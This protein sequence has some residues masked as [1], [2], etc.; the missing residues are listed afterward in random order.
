MG[1]KVDRFDYSRKR[2]VSITVSLAVLRRVH[3]R[4]HP[5]GSPGGESGPRIGEAVVWVEKGKSKTFQS[6]YLRCVRRR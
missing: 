1:G 2:G 6:S 5:R 4:L 3:V